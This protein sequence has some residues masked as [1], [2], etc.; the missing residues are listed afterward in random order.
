MVSGALERHLLTC[1]TDR[2]CACSSDHSPVSMSASHF[3]VDTVG[4]GAM[5]AEGCAE[6]IAEANEVIDLY[7][8]KD[9]SVSA[10]ELKVSYFAFFVAR[11]GMGPNYVARLE[12]E[13]RILSVYLVA[14]SVERLLGPAARVD[15]WLLERV[16]AVRYL[17]HVFRTS[18]KAVQVCGTAQS[19]ASI[20]RTT[21]GV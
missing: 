4:T 11:A 21:P 18:D 10:S 13:F 6:A 15:E 1:Q 12:R 9:T 16:G 8:T 14:H 19:N 3:A 17:K 20:F 5:G 2:A 7:A